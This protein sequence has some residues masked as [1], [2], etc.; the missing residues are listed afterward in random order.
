VSTAAPSVYVPPAVHHLIAGMKHQ[1]EIECQARR[2]AEELYLEEMRKRIRV[3]EVVDRLQK[4]R[5]REQD[6]SQPPAAQSVPSVGARVDVAG[7]PDGEARPTSTDTTHSK[8]TT[9]GFSA[10]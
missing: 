6:A 4:E 1:L 8:V 7:Q 10:T 9:G 5:T 2:R 3:E